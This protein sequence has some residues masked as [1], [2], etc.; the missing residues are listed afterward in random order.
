[1]DIIS[2]TIHYTAGSMAKFPVWT[3]DCNIA[4]TVQDNIAMSKS[5]WDSYETSWD[6]KKNPLV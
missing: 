6:F 4:N 1:M 3:A 2:P 5:D